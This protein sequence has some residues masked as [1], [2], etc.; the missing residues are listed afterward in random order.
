MK[1]VLKGRRFGT[2]EDIQ[3]NVVNMLKVLPVQIGNYYSVVVPLL[4]W[5]NVMNVEW[6]KDKKK[7]TK[8]L[9]F[10]F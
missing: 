3:K 7:K 2:V 10:Y 6:T 9:Y 8:K 4:K 5:Y 1:T